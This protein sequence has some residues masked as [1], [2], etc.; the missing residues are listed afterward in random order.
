M[1]R[2][3]AAPQVTPLSIARPV[4]V[5]G[6]Y[7]YRNAG[8]EAILDGLLRLIGHDAVTVVSRAPAETAARH[9]VR[10]IGVLGALASLRVHRG[11]VIGG[12]GLFGR[13]MGPLG[14]LLPLFG[15][16]ATQAGRDVALVGVGF[17]RDA[18]GPSAR[19]TFALARQAKTVI[20]R[21]A[22]SA[23]LLAT[24]Q[25]AAQ[26]W[27]DLSALV[28]SAG[29]AAGVAALRAAGL[30]P[31]RRPVVG[32]CLT[33]VEP[34]LVEP[35]VEAVIGA[36]DALPET[37]F[38][39]IPMSRHPF[40]PAHND[41]LLAV[42]LLQARPRLRILPAIEDPARLLGVFDALCGAVCMRFHSLLFAARA[43]IP[44]V[45]IAY[46]EK[47]QHWLRE[48]DLRPAEPTAE[49]IVAGLGSAPRLRTA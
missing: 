6:G 40:V 33:A 19:L 25:V 7:G 5:V 27:P 28:P 39:L 35:V 4:L 44:I 10:S 36:V 34:A 31:D 20:V 8:D 37:D 43:D 48:H 13:H 15:L 12:G 16:L 11:V 17:D 32:L 23:S 21:D 42:R 1:A 47:C 26:V 29:R 46:A 41:E 45:P 24:R 22:D 2:P 49:A 3:D 18:A 14:R 9:G 38:C 30:D